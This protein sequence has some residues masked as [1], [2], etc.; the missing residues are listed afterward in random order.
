MMLQS[1]QAFLGSLRF[2]RRSSEHTIASYKTDLM[3]ALAFFEADH[4]N[5]WQDI[6]ESTIRALLAFRRNQKISPRTLNRQLSALRTF[7]R[8]LMRRGL[9]TDNKAMR[10]LALKTSRALPRALDVD[11]MAKLLELPASNPFAIRDLAIMELLYSTGLRVSE[12]VSL[13]VRDLDLKQQQTPVLGKGKKSRLA[14]I[15]RCAVKALEQWLSI[16]TTLAEP[17]EPALFV[18]NKGKRLSAR[19][20]QYRLYNIGIQQGVETRVTPHRLRH[21]FA[22]HLLE[23]SN[24][25]RAVQELLGHADLSTTQIYTK[26]N[27]QHLAN[28]YDKCH[29]RA[30][31]QSEENKK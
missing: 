15:G 8:Y 22:S 1:V 3:D 30:R 5:T 12:I 14:L 9:I 27:F 21:S 10:V 26:V 29:P 4:L 25:L 31:K 19:S 7:F 20:I 16:R 18:N 11:Q 6:Q 2:E 17:V 24:D 13:N 23:S 28:V